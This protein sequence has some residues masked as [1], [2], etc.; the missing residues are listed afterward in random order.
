MGEGLWEVPGA[1]QG[2]AVLHRVLRRTASQR[3]GPFSKD[4]KEMREVGRQRFGGRVSRAEGRASAKVG[5]CVQHVPADN[6]LN[7]SW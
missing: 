2:L 4:L 5:A 1:G 6:A 3:R 7:Q